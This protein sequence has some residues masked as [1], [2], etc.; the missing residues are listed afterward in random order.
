ML[1][2]LLLL[3]TKA[4]RRQD[5]LRA[6]RYKRHVLFVRSGTRGD[7]ESRRGRSST[8]C[9]RSSALGGTQA[10]ALMLLL[11]LLLTKAAR[12]QDV[13]RARRLYRHT[14]FVRSGTR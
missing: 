14:L 6:R 9:R 1:L 13:L 3:L 12:R 5:V 7:T 2:L 11:L 8:H 4:A 10:A